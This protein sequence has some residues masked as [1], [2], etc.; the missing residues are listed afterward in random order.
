[1]KTTVVCFILL[2][3]GLAHAQEAVSPID[4]EVT[5][6][7]EPLLLIPGFTVPGD[8]W[9][10]I[11]EHLESDFECHVVTMAGFGG[12]DPI[13]FPWLPKITKALQEYMERQGL[14]NVRVMGHS[15]GGTVGTWLASRDQSPV[16]ELIL[17]DALPAAGALMIPDFD[18]DKLSYESPYNDQLMAMDKAQF[19]LMA[20]N[21][22]QGMSLKASSREKITDWILQADRK[23]YV[24]GY[25]DY[26][27]LD[28]REDLK[29]ISVPV[30][31]LAA[32]RPY[33]KDMVRGTYEQQYKNLAEYDIFIAENA[34]HFI[35]FDQPE[36][37]LEK[38]QH[39]LLKDPMDK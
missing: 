13:E 4:V 26:L 25:T 18:P 9:D 5:G 37:F 20:S 7:G 3:M 6:K 39:I 17:I 34:A 23:T 11:V 16:T 36:W 29:K 38:I 33:G 32:D 31:I 30:T 15:L 2:I 35:M 24:Y 1:M 8:I 27:Q 28:M 14:Q 12:K 19:E 21:M 22:A 10:P